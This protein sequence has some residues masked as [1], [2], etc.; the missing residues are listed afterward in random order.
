VVVQA[1]GRKSN[2]FGAKE[3][4]PPGDAKQNPFTSSKAG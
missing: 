2:P 1:T 4:K 3:K